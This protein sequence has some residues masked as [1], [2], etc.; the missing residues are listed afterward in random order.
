MLRELYDNFTTRISSF[1]KEA[2]INVKGVKVDGRYLHHLR[3]GDDIVLITPNI[4]QA[5]RMLAES[6]RACGRIGLRLN[7]TMTMFMK[8]GLVPDTPSR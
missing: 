1:Y 7:S 5:E 4:E 8:N 6:D 3:F 2:I